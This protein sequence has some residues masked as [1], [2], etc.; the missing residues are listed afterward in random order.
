[1]DHGISVVILCGLLLFLSCV[2]GM[3]P[4]GKQRCLCRGKNAG[5]ID[6]KSLEKLEV[7]PPSP[8]CEKIEIIATMKSGY[9]TCLNPKSKSIQQLMS[10]VRK[11]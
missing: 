11:K 7:F 8:V 4:L 3:S 5:R 1:M 9:K 2:L 10:A 6:V